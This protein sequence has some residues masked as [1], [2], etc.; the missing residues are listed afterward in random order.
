[1]TSIKNIFQI[2]NLSFSALKVYELL[3]KRGIVSALELSRELE[4]P[5]ST[6][7]LELNNLLN[8]GLISITGSYK[9]RRYVI[10][11]PHN[12]VKI[13]K[14][15][16]E[17]FS[18]LIDQADNI[19]DNINRQIME[20]KWG[21]PHIKFYRGIDGVKKVMN[22]CLVAKNKE[23]LAIIPAYDLYLVVGER[24]LKK[25]IEQRIKNKIKAKNIWPLGQEMPI[26]LKRHS[27]REKEFWHEV[28][29]SKEQANFKSAI[30]I[31][32]NT[33]IFITSTDELFCVQIKSNDLAEAMKVLFKMVWE[34]SLN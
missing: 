6:V 8:I 26:F 17:M 16:Q 20:S 19:A 7:Y 29:F 14:E 3:I 13:I 31:Y 34:N 10:D 21:N 9:K 28:R 27:E 33:I 24:Y 32:D 15:R 30:L 12:I 4:I 18:E 23:I 5:R 22:S 11:N 1:M 2:L 25:F